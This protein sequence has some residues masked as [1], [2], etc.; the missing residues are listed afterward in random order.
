M[1]K[2]PFHHRHLLGI[3][4]LSAADI[5]TILDT[6]RSMRTTFGGTMKQA[7]TLRGRSVFT[8]FFEASTRTRTSFEIAAKRLSANVTSF[9]ASASSLTKGESLADTALTLN[10]MEPELIIM[11]HSRSGSPH[12]VARHVDCPVINAGDGTHE[13]PTQALLDA[14]TM[15]DHKPSLDGLN[16][17]IV[18]DVLHSRVARSNLLLLGKMGANVTLCGPR[19]LVPAEFAEFA[20]FT[21][22]APRI[23]WN[24]DEAVEGQDVIM[25]LRIQLE[26]QDQAFFPDLR[27]Y[28]MLYGVNPARV[29]RARKDAIVMHPGPMNRGVEINPHVADGDQS[30]VLEQ[31]KNGIYVRMALVYLLMGAGPLEA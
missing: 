23:S 5:T 8:L 20:E 19:T 18:G 28:A 4:Q 26:R 1:T 21:G 14:L 13:H 15:L 25:T 17:L 12:Y 29:K 2:P 24:M 22:R 10:A 11:R 31:V 16:V 27:E 3:D 30:V 7:P 9:N 6:A